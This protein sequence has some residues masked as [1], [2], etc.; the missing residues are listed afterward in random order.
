V[1]VPGKPF[2]TSLMFVDKAGAYPIV[3]HPKTQHKNIT[4]LQYTD[5]VV[6]PRV[7]AKGSVFVTDNKKDFK[8]RQLRIRNVLSNKPLVAISTLEGS[9][10]HCRK[11]R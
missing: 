5:S 4:F 9:F 6:S 7:F 3:E 10:T 11:S 2:Q 1:F 8:I